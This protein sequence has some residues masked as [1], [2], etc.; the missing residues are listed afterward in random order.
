MSHII[1]KSSIPG[2]HIKLKQPL[3]PRIQQKPTMRTLVDKLKFRLNLS[4]AIVKIMLKYD[5]KKFHPVKDFTV[6][7]DR[8]KVIPN[9]KQIIS[10]PHIHTMTLQAM[11]PILQKALTHR[12]ISYVIV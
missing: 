2:Q 3:H 5:R 10:A 12:G 8:P 9:T 11:E 1:K 7:Y 6:Y 4:D